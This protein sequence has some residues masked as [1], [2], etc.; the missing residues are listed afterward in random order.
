MNTINK[1]RLTKCISLT[2]SKG[3]SLLDILD[4]VEE[5]DIK[6]TNKKNICKCCNKYIANIKTLEEHQVKC[7]QN[8]I[9]ELNTT[10]ERFN[11]KTKLLEENIKHEIRIRGI[12][13][14]IERNDNKWNKIYNLNK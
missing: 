4:S 12:E 3:K 14:L 2:I 11:I 13:L 5:E 10:I 7:F 6:D 9:K 8:K 1:P